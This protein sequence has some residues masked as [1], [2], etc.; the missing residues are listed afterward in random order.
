VKKKKGDKPVKISLDSSGSI[1][2]TPDPVTIKTKKHEQVV[3]TAK[4]GKIQIDFDKP[5]GSPFASPSFSA[6]DGK[7]KGSGQA[8]V[9]PVPP[10]HFRYSV[11][12][13][14]PHGSAVELDP[15]VDVD[16]GG[17]P[18]HKK[19]ARKKAGR[20]KA[21]RKAARKGARKKATRKSAR[22]KASRKKK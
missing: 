5:E 20:K 6:S 11:T 12:F 4:G 21:T 18:P 15:G 13:T 1:V 7:P 3:W 19:A 10:Q 17:P 14:P 8:N 9:Q 16:G 2:V 22:K